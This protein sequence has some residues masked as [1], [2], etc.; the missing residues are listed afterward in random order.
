MDLPGEGKGY[1]L[2]YSVLKNSMDGVVHGVAKSRTRL[3][4]FHFGKVMSR[5]FDMLSRL[6]IAFLARSKHVLIS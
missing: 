2:Q 6:V 4:D 3:S 1:S 5:L